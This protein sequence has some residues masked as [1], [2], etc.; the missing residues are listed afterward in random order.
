MD[1]DLVY[2]IG[3]TVPIYRATDAEPF[4]AHGSRFESFVRTARGSDALCAWRLEV[5]PDTAGVSHRPSREEVILVLS[6]SA[7]IVIDGVAADVAAGD[8]VHV[9]TGS[10]LAVDGGPDGATAWVTTTAGLTARIGETTIA[11]PWAQ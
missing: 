11:P 2:L 3:G 6:G 9:P 10:E 1:K 4:E 7:T 8:V 5:A